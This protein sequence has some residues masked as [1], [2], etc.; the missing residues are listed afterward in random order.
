M[1]QGSLRLVRFCWQPAILFD[2]ARHVSIMLLF[3]SSIPCRSSLAP[4][5]LPACSHIRAVTT[6]KHPQAKMRSLRKVVQDANLAY[7]LARKPVWCQPSTIFASGSAITSVSFVIF[8]GPWLPIAWLSFGAVA[9][10]WYVF[11]FLFPLAVIESEAE[12]RNRDP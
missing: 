11:L 7:S 2:S 3:L 8:R 12:H 5:P 6:R 1:L 10:W 9:L 4:H